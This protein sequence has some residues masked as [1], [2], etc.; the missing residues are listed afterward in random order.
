MQVRNW[1]PGGQAG[2]AFGYQFIVGSCDMTLTYSADH[3]VENPDSARGRE[4]ARLIWDDDPAMVALVDPRSSAFAEA[5]I[6]AS[7]E[8]LRNSTGLIKRMINR[9]AAGAEDLAV[10]QF[11]GIIEVIQNADDVRA[12]Q[13]RFA[14]RNGLSGQQLLIVHDGEPVTCLN[15]L[16]MALP[17]LTSKT[18]RTDQR[19]RFG[20]GMK[21][22]KRIANAVSVH[23]SPYHFSSDQL[24]F[25][26]VKAEAAIPGFY[27]PMRH[28]MLVA[29]LNDGFQ[30][31]ALA[32][33]FESWRDDG[34]LFLASVS[35]LSWCELD[36]R[37]RCERALTFSQWADAEYPL[38]H[39]KIRRLRC[40]R[41]SGP[42]NNWTIWRATVHVPHYLHPAH[43]ARSEETDVSIAFADVPDITGVFIGFR[44]QVPISL[45]FSL[46][47]QFDPSTSREAIIENAWNSWLVER[48]A[49]VVTN[50]AAGLL[51]S[52]P[53]AAWG[54]IP[55][56][57]ESVGE[58][59]DA[60]L[61]KHFSSALEA[62]RA[63]LGQHA[64]IRLPGGASSLADLVFEQD[65]LTGFL[66]E[67]DAER[68]LENRYA[69]HCDIRDENGRWRKV[70][71]TLDV[72]SVLGT[73]D[74]LEA[75]SRGVFEQKPVGW[76][77][78]AGS[79]L[80]EHHP[81]SELFGRPFL[82]SHLCQP[83][84]CKAIG[85][86]AR[87]LAL[88]IAPSAFN[89]RWGLL[90]RLHS[91]YATTESGA[92]VL[93]WLNSCAA[94]VSRLDAAI[95]LAAFAEKFDGEQIDI[96]DEDLRELRTRF[97]EIPDLIA[98][99]LGLKVGTVLRLD[100]HVFSAGKL[101]RQKVALSESYLCKTI[102]GENSTWPD[103]AGSTSKIQW[104]AA[105]YEAVLKTEAGRWAKR[106]R[107]DGSVSRGPRKF[108]TLLGAETSPRV[109]KL[110]ELRYGGSPSRLAELRQKGAE[111]VRFD[112]LSPDLT[113]VLKSLL[114]VSK[115]DAKPRSPA[116]L[117]TLSRNWDR[118]YSNRL[119]VPAVHQAV[120]YLHQRGEVTA[121]WLNELRDTNWI[122]VG[123]SEMVAPRFAVLRAPE[124]QTTYQTFAYD[125]VGSD[126]HPDLS[127]ALGLITDVRVGDLL[128]KL[129]EL[130]DGGESL[131]SAQTLQIYRAIA[132]RCP[133]SVTFNSRVGELTVQQLRQRF[134]AREGLIYVAPR[135]WHRPDEL[136]RGMDIFHDR[137]AFVPGGTACTN[138][139]LALDVAEPEL[140][141]CIQFCRGL[142]QEPYG[143]DVE[144]ALMDVYRYMER[145]L[146]T[147]ERRH[148]D[149]LRALPLFC[150]NGWVVARPL[151]YVESPELREQLVKAVPSLYCWIPPCDVRDF[152]R[153][154][155]AMGVQALKPELQVDQKGDEAIER[156]EQLRLRFGH[157]VDHLSV[158]L[159]RSVPELRER[160]AIGWDD[161]KKVPLF[162][163]QHAITV[164]ASS[165][166]L[167]VGG[168]FVSLKALGYENPHAFYFRDDDLGSRDYGGRIIASLFPAGEQRRIGGEWALAWQKS[169]DT[170][171][172]AIRL[173][174]D[175][176]RSDAMQEAAAAIN[177]RPKSKINVTPP[178]SRDGVINPRTLKASVGSVIG[179]TVQQGALRVKPPTAAGG[180]KG[181]KSNPPQPNKNENSTPIAPVAYTNADLEQRGWEILV[182]ALETSA[183]KRLVDFRK[184]HG[185]GADGVFDWKRFVEMKATA[186]SAQSQIELSNNEFERA[187]QRGSDFILALVSGLETG[188]KDE[189][190]LIFDPTNCT[191]VRPT[192]GVR[193]VGLLDAP[194]VIIHFES[195]GDI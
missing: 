134:L 52:D 20:I 11:Q 40:R 124:T 89:S 77:V 161:L 148:R 63:W 111:L 14:L 144:A 101:S 28:T 31:S 92:S 152:P 38:H 72:S 102:D 175:E 95:E 57:D 58:V 66:R 42:E 141:D 140:D 50:I 104:I 178:K 154:V 128:A 54:F 48:V 88:D 87:P 168:V 81:D 61:C 123:R 94:F 109:V 173:A 193:L 12:T 138:L 107:D 90:E 67:A 21:T 79:R 68:M 113:L 32:E 71:E 26:R 121:A 122:A 133:T 160:L 65:V 176:M 76:W 115:R 84:S 174:S 83:I 142:A 41:V 153:L 186:R 112:Y 2:V 49:E 106:K 187:K 163:Y 16:G 164:K 149:K 108:L 126:I 9:A 8:A 177:A 110:E 62:S 114:T 53:K 119:A 105:R 125:V 179:A 191:N 64:I 165:P 10:A 39:S 96:A 139:W 156:G 30:E 132:K 117:R 131:N 103:A 185:V 180:T 7:A 47:A 69:L 137:R 3:I 91:M 130:R 59:R 36:G 51:E 70:M 145:M 1:R 146:G 80:V 22:L 74:L 35:R 24:K 23:S 18:E 194:S 169:R 189:V 182:Q 56:A 190:R 13:V 195:S 17:Y 4:A 172:E 116:L 150:E 33:W 44:T 120:K 167:P 46:D 82:L 192:N 158:E 166:E 55:L 19:G 5:M 73:G 34:L 98:G 93:T 43:K 184:N 171:A 60:W 188:Q 86:T 129:E 157:A 75:I 127:T 45:P 78:E 162:V 151:F 147:V 37:V 181:L 85:E 159:A 136:M 27:E 6:D 143:A 170:A 183:D 15:V 29:D 100:G 155:A 25:G 118:F 97:D 99:P 135:G